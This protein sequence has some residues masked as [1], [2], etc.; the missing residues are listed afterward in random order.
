MPTDRTQPTLGRDSIAQASSVYSASAAYIA[1]D[2]NSGT[3]WICNG[4]L[5][6]TPAWLKYDFGILS[7]IFASPS[8]TD[9]TS[10]KTATA[11]STAGSGW[12]ASRAIND[13]TSDG[14]SSSN[15]AHPHWLKID[16][17]AGNTKTIRSY[18]I[19]VRDTGANAPGTWLFQGSNDNS[20]WTTLDSEDNLKWA[21]GEKDWFINFTEKENIAA[22]RYYR[23]YVTKNAGGGTTGYTQIYELELSEDDLSAQGQY[24]SESYNIRTRPS[25]YHQQ[26]PGDFKYQGSNDNI[27]WTDLDTHTGITWVSNEVKTYSF[28]N[29]N[30]YRFYRVYITATQH[31]TYAAIT[32]M[33]IFSTEA[34]SATLDDSLS[35]S[36]S[37]ELQT[38]PDNATLDDTLTLSDF[39][40]LITT[41]EPLNISDS[42]S[43]D[44]SWSEQ[45]NPDNQSISDSLSLNDSWSELVNPETQL[46]GDTL[47]LSDTYSFFKIFNKIINTDLHWKKL[48]T[49]VVKTT[50]NWIIAKCINTNLTWLGI[51]RKIMNTDLRWLSL[52][53]NDVPP[54]APSDIQIFIN[55]VD[56]VPLN[57]VDLSTGNI[58]HTSGQKSIATFTLA[59]KHDDL[60]RT[61]TGA[62]SQITNQNPVQ[63]YIKGNL[64]FNG[65]ISNLAVNSESETIQVT[66]LMNEPAN[67]RHSIELPLPSVNEKLHLYHCLVNN[68]QIDNPYIDPGELNPDYYKGIK[69]DMGKRI[70]QQTDTWREIEYTTNGKGRIATSVEDGTFIPKPNYNYFWNVMAKNVRTGIFNGNSRYIGTSLGSIAT[71]LWVLNGAS[72][73]RQKIKDNIET[74]LG[75]YY[76]GSAPYK[77]IS[78]KNGQLIIAAKYQDRDDGLYHVYDESYN[79]ID[80]AKIVAGLEY[81]KL[82]N[83]G[84]DVLPITSSNIEI[85]FDAYYYYTVKLL[86]RINVTNTTVANTFKNTNGFPVSVK[87]ISINF[88]TMKITLS[89]DNRLSKEELD[90]IDTQMP[91]EENPIYLV[92]ESSARVYRKFD[93]KTWSYVS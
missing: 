1:F 93:L 38:N 84:G 88:S 26:G 7:S 35:L 11:D 8:I 27:S 81:Q 16:Y 51:S 17:G 50:L 65:F 28:S 68:V 57:D 15:S 49:N 34:V 63:I 59:R 74:E 72:P 89:T 64:E 47:K 85:T 70:Q 14:W 32:E 78:S 45:V 83:V 80:F 24:Q 6:G 58:I 33:E 82:L 5:P 43:L 86:T 9:T 20:N 19:R 54:I 41:Y 56:L 39:W 4:G 3:D 62:A 60:D 36:D 73:L 46:I 37:F 23:I 92:P 71:D 21:G 66:C 44:D 61:H 13:I 31:A 91:D 87:S 40:D 29:S 30:S 67:N 69:V 2:N 10:G 79:Y 12:E 48:Y 22:F 18:S 25:P 42:L 77:E 90:E 55:S 53:Y 76:V 52:G 75:Y